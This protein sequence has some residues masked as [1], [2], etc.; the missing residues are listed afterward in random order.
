MRLFASALFIII[1]FLNI[2]VKAQDA[3]IK[4]FIEAWSIA[5]TSQT[6]KYI[7]IC[8]LSSLRND[9]TK[10]R[11]IKK[12]YAYIDKHPN[13]RLLVRL[14]LF[15]EPWWKSC[16]KGD[17]TG[18][19]PTI[20]KA[21]RL[22][23]QENDE[24]LI[25]DVYAA[26]AEFCTRVSLNEEYLFYSAKALEMQRKIGAV[27][28]PFFGS[29]LFNMCKALYI[30]KDYKQSLQYGLECYKYDGKRGAY[31]FLLDLI[32]ANYKKLRLYD[33]SLYYYRLLVNTIQLEISKGNNN[34]FFQKWL[35]IA[36]GNI[37]ENLVLKKNYEQGMPLLQEYAIKS[38]QTD[39]RLNV[40]LANNALA[41]GY[42][43]RHQY[44][45]ALSCWKKAYSMST[46]LNNP[47]GNN[48]EYAAK[49][50]VGIAGIYKT[51]G[52]I[53]SAFLYTNLFHLYTDSLNA[54]VSRSNLRAVKAKMAF[55][56]MQNDLEKANSAI[57]QERMTRNFILAGIL[58]L[59]VIALLLYNRKRLKEKYE[60]EILKRKH[61]AA[62]QEMKLAKEE[63]DTFARHIVEKNNLIKALQF[64]L[65]SDASGINRADECV[66]E[67]LTKYILV[68]DEEWE[69]FRKEFVLAYPGFFSALTICIEKI[70]PAEV[71][72]SA[73][74]Y[75]QLDNYQ[76]ANTLGISKESVTRS[77]RRLK[78]RFNLSADANLEEYVC[79]LIPTSPKLTYRKVTF[80]ETTP[81]ELLVN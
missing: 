26:Y 55:D 9:V 38:E 64:E 74:I 60:A 54:F 5:D 66:I 76:I 32:G 20:N 37:G 43:A 25:S 34:D 10:Q 51:T 58:L 12:L 59:V 15:D 8:R 29:G 16:V 6:R 30:T 62:E 81:D 7:E 52:A 3:E 68:T 73:L 1:C 71:R 75:L 28:F 65:A 31:I 36:S 13:K 47:D 42:F 56:E 61:Q 67:S 78:Q 79:A 4:P 77:K 24:Q 40:I 44:S 80:F 23:R 17:G 70:T 69:K 18:G 46:D 33:S 22:A 35:V 57:K 72:L 14:M 21:V 41:N 50:A 19:R 39:D 53:D 63:I 27:H 45:L 48:Q 2:K 11:I 49:A